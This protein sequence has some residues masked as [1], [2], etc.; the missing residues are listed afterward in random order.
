MNVCIF[1]GSSAGL[2]KNFI[3]EARLLGK[4]LAQHNFGLVYGGASIGL[5]G[6]VANAAIRANGT[7][8]GVIPETLE[9]R[10]VT[11][12]GLSKL[13]VTQS[14]HERKA[15]M[16]TLSDVFLTLPGGFG[17]L[18]E[19]FE[20]ITWS[21][22]NIHQK[23]IILLNTNGYFDMLI[24]FLQE[25]ERQGFIKPDNLELFTLVDS[26][27]SC[28]QKLHDIAETSKTVT[29]KKGLI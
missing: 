19:L 28:M 1:C 21:Q 8:T 15:A 2:D 6:A 5:M 18:E 16:A 20:T 11:H 14:M 17:T 25:S 7:V 10:E 24:R 4:T 13:I 12:N 3:A 27:R 22:L 29:F 26:V 23:P 9:K